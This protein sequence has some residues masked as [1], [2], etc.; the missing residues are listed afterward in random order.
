MS[1][2]VPLNEELLKEISTWKL[3][4]KLEDTARYFYH[5]RDLDRIEN[6][7]RCYVIGRKGTGKTA[8]AEYLLKKHDAKIFPVKLSFKNFPFNDLYDLENKRFRTPN[9]YITLWKYLIYSSIAK[10]MKANEA[11]DSNLR[12]S[13]DRVYSDDPESSLSRRI[14]RWTGKTFEFRVLGTGAGGGKTQQ[15]VDNDTTWIDRVEL[16]E[17]MISDHIDDSFY[18]VIFDELDEDYQDILL[19]DRREQ[20]T[21]LLTSLFKAVQDVKSV[22]LN[23]QF[24]ILPIVFLRDDIY[25]ILHDPDKTKWSDLSIGLDWSKDQIK[26]LLAFR[27]SRAI[28]AEGRILDFRSAWNRIFSNRPVHYGGRQQKEISAFEYITR[29]SHIRPRDYIRYLQVCAEEALLHN[30]KF[31]KPETVV[32]VDKAFSNYMRSEFEDEIHGFLPEISQVLDTVGQIRKQTFSL[33]EFSLAYKREVER[34]FLE[35]RNVEFVLR[36]LFHFSIIG[37]Q[38]RQKNIQVFKYLNKEARFNL[39]ESICVHRGLFKALQIL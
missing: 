2:Q 39:N 10:L 18:L 19:T 7:E 24:N 8:I 4:A 38:P 12:S 34:G 9:Q 25:D 22:F 36:V 28:S 15:S 14:S 26:K 1:Q 3:E 17:R 6:G 11:I 23:A 5:V 13:L 33:E 31:I 30:N 29:S 16:L 27:I 21:S 35:E 37:N 32:W 20:Y